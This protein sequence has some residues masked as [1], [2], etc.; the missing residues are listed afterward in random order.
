MADQKAKPVLSSKLM[1]MRFMQRGAEKQQL[2]KA[3]QAK[4]KQQ[5]E[6]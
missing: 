2:A 3:Q 5:D 4:E 1:Q 6:V